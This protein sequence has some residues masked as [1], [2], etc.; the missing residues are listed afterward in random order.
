VAAARGAD[1]ERQEAAIAANA[2]RL[3]GW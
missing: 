1:P 2:A 3:L